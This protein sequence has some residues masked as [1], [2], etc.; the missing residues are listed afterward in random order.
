MSWNEPAIRKSGMSVGGLFCG[1]QGY[2]FSSGQFVVQVPVGLQGEGQVG[3]WND[4][5]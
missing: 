2:E 3:G 4:Q 5:G 1:R